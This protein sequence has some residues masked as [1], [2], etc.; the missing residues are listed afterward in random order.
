MDARA[1]FALLRARAVFASRD[2]WSR[3]ELLAHQ[4]RAL[5][6]LR[7]FAL[8]RSPFYR[9]F[10]RG[11]RVAP[12]D[13]LPVLTKATLMERFDELVTDPDVRFGDVEAHLASAGPTDLFRGRYRVAATGGT[14]GR[15]GVFLSDRS[16]WTSVLA[17]YARANDWAGVP[18][19]LRHR[20][21]VAVVSSRNPS[22][23]SSIVGATLASP[24]VPTLRLDAVD[25]LERTT[26][27]LN[28]FRP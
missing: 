19:G 27:A 16:E 7:A 10:H 12:L 25:P 11:L 24:I 13:V 2:R 14:T 23:Q 6:D 1:V 5:A 20:L 21:R 26:D 22:H 18:A 3:D 17:S 4:S 9:E 28:S 15:R 8:A